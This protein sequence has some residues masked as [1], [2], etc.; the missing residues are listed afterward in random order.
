MNPS[1]SQS[2]NAS[3]VAPLKAPQIPLPAH[4]DIRD[5]SNLVDKW[6]TWKQ[7][8]NS[9]IIVTQLNTQTAAYQLSFF[10]HAIGP[11]SLQIYNSFHYSEDKDKTLVAT[12][13]AKLDK[14]FIGETIE[15]YERY[16]FNKRLQESNESIDICVN[17]V[18]NL[19]KTC[20]FFECLHDTLIRYQIVMVVRD[21]AIRKRLL[22]ERKLI[23]NT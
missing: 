12:V 21:Y 11:D 9:Y 5:G 2:P 4:L 13:I 10:L 15:T 22:Q 16:R 3:P 17:A 14:H 23:L 8:W 7:V 18:R 1:G 6:K 20:N 19:A